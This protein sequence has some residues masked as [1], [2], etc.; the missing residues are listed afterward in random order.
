MAR[1]DM[2]AL[3]SRDRLLEAGKKLMARDGYERTSTSAIVRQAGTSESQLMRYFGGKAGLLKA[4]FERDWT[5][6][7][8][9]LQGLMGDKPDARSGLGAILELFIKALDRDHDMARL[10]LFEG[11]RLRGHRRQV[12]LSQGFAEFITSMQDLIRRAQRDGELDA[13]LD[14][15]AVSTAVMGLAEGM[16]RDRLVYRELN[17]RYPFSENDVRKVFAVMTDGLFAKSASG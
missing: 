6:L 1:D 5:R 9:D 16:V 13:T 3:T 10:L 7:N 15:V 17:G 14:P 4:I 8:V 11:R 2:P 12:T